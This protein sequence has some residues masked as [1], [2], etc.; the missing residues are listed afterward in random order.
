MEGPAEEGFRKRRTDHGCEG[1]GDK[2]VF[3]PGQ[4]STPLPRFP[5]R[6]CGKLTERDEFRTHG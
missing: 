3:R 1:K 4:I 2:E 5:R 6:G